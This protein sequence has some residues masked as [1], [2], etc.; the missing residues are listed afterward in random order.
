MTHE[1]TNADF[2]RAIAIGLG[3]IALIGLVLF[4]VGAISGPFKKG[5]RR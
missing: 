5:P 3:L 2:L 1:L 4:V